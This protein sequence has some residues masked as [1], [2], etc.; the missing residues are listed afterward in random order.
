MAVARISC[1]LRSLRRERQRLAMCCRLQASRTFSADVIRK[2]NKSSVGDCEDRKTGRDARA[3]CF[4]ERDDS[5]RVV[6][7][8]WQ[9][10]SAAA[11]P[12]G[13]AHS[14]AA[15]GK[16]IEVEERRQGR[17]RQRRLHGN[18]VVAGISC[19]SVHKMCTRL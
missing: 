11:D 16:S 4:A 12:E 13:F 3:R 1:T 5:S 14:A 15:K 8:A 19:V 6:S 10:T 9:A 17:R 18:V 2:H 7:R